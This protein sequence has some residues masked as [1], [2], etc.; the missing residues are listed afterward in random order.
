M[1]TG[2]SCWSFKLQESLDKYQEHTIYTIDVD[3]YAY[4][5]PELRKTTAAIGNRN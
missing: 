1:A 4:V 2:E 3:R 5:D